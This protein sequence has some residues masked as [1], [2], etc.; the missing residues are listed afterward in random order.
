VE[1]IEPSFAHTWPGVVALL[2]LSAVL[3]ALAMG[4]L[5]RMGR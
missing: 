3:A 1:G 2:G 5:R 4:G